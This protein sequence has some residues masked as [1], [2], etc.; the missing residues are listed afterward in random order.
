MHRKMHHIFGEIRQSK[1]IR[2]YKKFPQSLGAY[3]HVMDKESLK[4]IKSLL[5]T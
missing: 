5:S 3:E 1:G 2:T 4:I